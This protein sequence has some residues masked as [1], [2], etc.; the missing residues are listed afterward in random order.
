MN[1]DY[2]KRDK[3][4]ESINTAFDSL[5]LRKECLK[6]EYTKWKNSENNYFDSI[7]YIKNPFDLQNAGENQIFDRTNPEDTLHL[8]FLKAAVFLSET[9][10]SYTQETFNEI[11]NTQNNYS[12]EVLLKKYFSKI[13]SIANE[14]K[15]SILI[16]IL[17]TFANEQAVLSGNRKVDLYKSYMQLKN[18]LNFMHIESFYLVFTLWRLTTDNNVLNFLIKNVVVFLRTYYYEYDKDPDMHL[19]YDL[20]NLDTLQQLNCISH[21]FSVICFHTSEIIKKYNNLNW[22]IPL[23]ELADTYMLTPQISKLEMLKYKIIFE[24]NNEIEVKNKAFCNQSYTLW[25]RTSDILCLASE[26]TKLIYRSNE[27]EKNKTLE[28]YDNFVKTRDFYIGKIFKHRVFYEENKKYLDSSINEIIENESKTINSLSNSFINLTTAILD[29]N[30]EKLVNS[31]KECL[32]LLRGKLTDEQL[33]YFDQYIQ[34]VIKSIQERIKQE[35][36][37]TSLYTNISNEFLNYSSK[38]IIYPNIFDSLVSAEYLYNQYVSNSEPINN[39]DYSCISIMY[40][41]ALE[42]FLNKIIFFPY[43]N[44]ILINYKKDD[45]KQIVSSPTSFWD[46]KNNC[47]KKHCEIGN[48]GYLLENINKENIFMKYMK[49]KFPNLVINDIVD[50]G[51]K[52]KHIANRRNNAAHGAHILSYK[53]VKEDKEI[54]FLINSINK[55]RGLIFRLLSVL[56]D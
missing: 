15:L 34:R 53:T 43:S 26:I 50:Y 4:I 42:E 12:K 39:F 54:V 1:N 13:K 14:K 27:K 41:M 49:S 5:N 10:Y 3:Q 51:K 9:L 22:L 28:L 2:K 29:T 46:K 38:L 52:L 31:K 25:V 8:E 55:N 19:N 33:E 6:K 20:S 56:Y 35:N 48:M 21:R 40:Y 36:S 7:L 18:S 45:W 23:D 24:D 44:S 16:V 32:A 11:K 30:L 17:N 37:Y 47:F